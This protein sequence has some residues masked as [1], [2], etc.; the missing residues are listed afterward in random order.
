MNLILERTDSVLWFTNMYTVFL[1]GSI[2]GV[3]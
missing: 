2:R 3:K 1:R